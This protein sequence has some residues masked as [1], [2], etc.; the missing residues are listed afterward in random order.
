M[1]VNS[2]YMYMG[3]AAPKEIHLFANGVANYEFTKVSG[4][5]TLDA[6]GLTMF[7]NSLCRFSGVPLSDK[8]KI[9]INYTHIAGS[10]S[11]GFYFYIK[12]AVGG[13]ELYS[14]GKSSTDS[15]VYEL[16]LPEKAKV[17]NA[18]VEIQ[19]QGYSLYPDI[20]FS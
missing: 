4:P 18:V 2:A 17:D 13:S 15:Q 20:A 8:S 3:K 12:N 9:T 1:I 16:E 10:A 7:A 11:S 6:N 5:S 19:A 14:V